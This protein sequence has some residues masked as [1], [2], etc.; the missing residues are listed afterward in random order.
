MTTISEQLDANVIGKLTYLPERLGMKVFEDERIVTVNTGI[1][2]DMFNVVCLKEYDA[3][4]QT[5]Q[6]MF[7]AAGLPFALQYGFGNNK[8]KREDFIEKSCVKSEEVES[9]MFMDIS[10]LSDVVHCAELEILQV[11][12]S[13]TLRDFITV[14]KGI[15]PDDGAAIEQFYSAAAPFIINSDSALK[16]FVGYIAERPIATGALFL[17]ADVA[18]IWDVTVLP[19]FRR[20]GIATDMVTRLL[21]QARDVYKYHTSVLTASDAGEKVYCKMGFQKIKEFYIRNV[22]G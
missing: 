13:R 14:Y 21:I 6:D 22:V 19:N 7:D 15:I 18:G 3:D 11:T 10:A 17:H 1:P 5:A 2:S 20:R 16:L 12:D 9:G 4:W 8:E